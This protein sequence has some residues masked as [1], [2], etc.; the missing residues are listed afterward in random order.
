MGDP[1]SIYQLQNYIVGLSWRGLTLNPDKSLDL[2]KSFTHINYFDLFTKQVV[3]NNVQSELSNRPIDFVATRLPQESVSEALSADMRSNEDAIWLNGGGDKQALILSRV[4]ADGGESYRYVPIASLTQDK[5]GKTTFQIK[6]WADGFPLKLYEEKNLLVPTADRIAWLNQWHTD[7][8]W[9]RATHKA[10]YS[11]AV[12]GLNEQIDRHPVFIDDGDGLSNDERVIRRF[13]QRQRNLT[14][15]DML[16]LASDHWNFDVQGFN[17]GGN[18][19]SFFRVSTNSSLMVSGGSKTG[20]PH[21]LVVDD[22]YDGISFVPTVLAMMGKIDERNQPDAD[23]TKRGFQRFPG[24]VVK[25]F[26]APSPIK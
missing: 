3:K 15:A 1:N 17:P 18:H 26:L 25:E 22:P 13:R 12:I 10:L 11:N 4:D 8:E 7:L 2:E 24:R 16:L 23:L 5:D 6:E 19:G 9:L 20:L 14:E 21:G